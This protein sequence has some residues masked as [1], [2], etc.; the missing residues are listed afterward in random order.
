MKN[1]YQFF[2]STAFKLISLL[3]ICYILVFYI[4]HES[5]TKMKT[6][7]TANEINIENLNIYILGTNEL[8]RTINHYHSQIVL[9][10]I[11]E[12]ADEKY[13]LKEQIVKSRNSIKKQLREI[14]K[15]EKDSITNSKLTKINSNL[16]VLEQNFQKLDSSIERT[17]I[18]LTSEN[19]ATLNS[20]IN[21]IDDLSAYYYKQ[22]SKEQK[23]NQKVYIFSRNMNFILFSLFS[24]ILPIVIILF[25]SKVLK[26]LNFI[27]F[28]LKQLSLGVVPR[29]RVDESKDEIG[30]I[31]I[32]TNDLSDYLSDTVFSINELSKNRFDI[33]LKS[34]S[35]NDKLYDS[36][37]RLKN[38]MNLLVTEL[39]VKKD[40]E[41]ERD[42]VNV[43][44]ANFSNILRENNTDLNIL[45]EIIL[46]ELIKYVDAVQGAIYTVEKEGDEDY[47]MMQT[48]YA[49]ETKKIAN[50]KILFNEGL[51]GR[52]AIERQNVYITDV[53]FDY[54]EIKSG[55]GQS[56]PASILLFPLVHHKTLYGVIELAFFKGLELFE[57]EFTE[58]LGELIASSIFNV[59]TNMKTANLLQQAQLHAQK[60]ALQERIMRRQLDE[61]QETQI[62]ADKK[63]E[64]SLGFVAA[65][66][67]TVIRAD[68]DLE[69][70]LLYANTKFYEIMEYSSREAE[71]K[72]FSM[73]L[74]ST[75]RDE[76]TE[77]WKRIS[78]GGKHFEKD[79]KYKTKTGY[80][81]LFVTYTIVRDVYAN[82]DK[83]L[84]LAIDTS[85]R[86]S[87]ELE[88]IKVIE[89][90]EKTSIKAEFA[91]DGTILSGTE[92]FYDAIGLPPEDLRGKNVPILL[93]KENI[94]NFEII[95][96]N[97]KSGIEFNNLLT[98]N[99]KNGKRTLAQVS[100]FPTENKDGDFV[101]IV[102]LACSFDYNDKKS[103]S[104]DF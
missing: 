69:G 1:K 27:K 7:Y 46:Q 42:W 82:L 8:K 31:A 51:V 2:N 71:G 16:D 86:I 23:L 40:S 54:F 25:S 90:F 33:V 89:A 53:P 21:L 96:Q 19:N 17:T 36:I 12:D 29:Y 95:W 6:I 65:V 77:E 13:Q 59:K 80:V 55:I 62:E 70:K 68:F 28:N 5:T 76:F 58:K 85:Q 92:K 83:V 41:N 63:E 10:L 98:F 15:I 14:N 48:S 73:F 56:K 44:L 60:M 99:N 20:L 81:Y 24:L 4:F 102:L 100:I 26:P 39:D 78:K 79:V 30:E 67:H 37:Y 74:D 75:D 72:H 93:K 103:F 84:F 9:H 97:A 94:I 50:K 57:R 11:S 104:L 61:L 35:T 45:F 34:K 22:L 88:M 43:G 66:N 49:Y 87:K 38:S 91:L 3:L 64:A 101:K 52:C 47:L 32:L 18:Y